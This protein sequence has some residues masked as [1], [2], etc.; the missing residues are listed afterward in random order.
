MTHEQFKEAIKIND[1][2]EQLKRVLK[3]FEMNDS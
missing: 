1:R 2:I 3:E